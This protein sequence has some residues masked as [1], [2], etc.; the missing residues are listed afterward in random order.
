MSQK[1]NKAV[2]FLNGDEDNLLYSKDHIDNQTLIVGCDGGTDKIHDL[3][4]KPHAVIGDF[5]SINTLSEKIKNLPKNQYG[6]EIL[7]DGITYVKYP[8]D[9]DF[10]DAELALDF[11]LNKKLKEVIL[12]N[13]DGNEPDH[14]LGMI[15]MLAKHKY[16]NLDVKIIRPKQKIYIARGKCSVIGKKG[17]KIS[18]IPIYGPVKVESSDGLKYDPAK[19]RMSLQH[20]L[21]ISN[22]LT[23]KKATLNISKGCFLVVHHS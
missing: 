8:V 1:F 16:R 20:N 3:G 4:F 19:Y 2:I 17:D 22:E 9:K 11:V 5:D 6:K 18:L 7:V 13:T 10:L 15:L 21:G 14:V 23:S 12:V